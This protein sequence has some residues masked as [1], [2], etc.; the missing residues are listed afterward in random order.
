MQRFRVAILVALFAHFS[1][2][3]HAEQLVRAVGCI[4][5]TVSD[6][7]RSVRFYEAALGPLGFRLESHDPKAGS[8][9][10]GPS[11]APALW[12][13]KGRSPGPLHLA[14]RAK[15]QAAVRRFHEAA[16]G[17]GGKDNGAPGP[18]E[19][20]APN[21]YAAFVLDPDGNNIEAVCLT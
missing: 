1:W 2:A 7:D 13:G 11:G 16:L 17:A 12:I 10:F 8:A 3:T 14:F 4:G 15:D 18:R 20:Y 5:L 9:G 6:F 19:N 21:Y